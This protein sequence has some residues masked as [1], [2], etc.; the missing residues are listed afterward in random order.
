MR[1]QQPAAGRLTDRLNHGFFSRLP[2]SPT[3]FS[4]LVL[5][6]GTRRAVNLFCCAVM[7]AGN[8][9]ALDNANDRCTNGT[10][11]ASHNAGTGFEQSGSAFDDSTGTKWLCYGTSSPWIRYQFTNG[12]AWVITNYTISTANDYA[13]RDPRNW[14]LEGSHNGST[15]TAVD[16]RTD[17]LPGGAPRFTTYSFTCNSG[18]K[19]PFEYYRLNISANWGSGDTQLSEI[20]M[21]G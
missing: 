9:Y 4:P 17:G 14:K 7:L 20:E 18:N 8:A 6:A 15:W 5:A 19:E 2:T 13:G 1:S 21:F 3:L 10:H 12:L 11:T 16:T